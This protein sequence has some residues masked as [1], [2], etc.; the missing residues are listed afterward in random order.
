MVRCDSFFFSLYV[1]VILQGHKCFNVQIISLKKMHKK[2]NC[3]TSEG[4]AG[5]R[6]YGPYLAWA[7]NSGGPKATASLSSSP[8]IV[9][10]ETGLQLPWPV[11]PSPSVCSLP[12]QGPS[13]TRNPS[14]FPLCLLNSCWVLGFSSNVPPS[15]TSLLCTSNR[16]LCAPGASSHSWYYIDLCIYLLDGYFWE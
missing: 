9:P 6:G 4:F 7:P 11:G 14:P 15:Y 3:L 10:C 2:E 1:H 16:L 12:P 8:S 5:K 13:S